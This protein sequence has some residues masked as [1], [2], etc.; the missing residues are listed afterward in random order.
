MMTGNP[1]VTVLMPVFNGA[2]HLA[3]TLESLQRQTFS[4]FE[5]LVV[6][7]GSTDDSM[8][9][10]RNVGDPRIRVISNDRNLGLVASLNRGSAEARGVFVA[11]QDADDPARH[12]RIARQVQF[13]QGNPSIPLLGS[14]ALLIDDS[15][16]WV[17]RW[18]SGG[19]ADLV[20][21]DCGFRT[22]FSHS[23]AMF[24]RD[25][26]VNRFGGY[27]DCR[28]CED[29]ELWGRVASE[30]PVVTLRQNLISYRQHGG[31][32]MAGE[33]AS[34]GGERRTA[35]YDV[36]VAN[37]RNL[38]PGTPDEQV[39]TIAT[40]WSQPMPD[41]DWVSYFAAVDGLKLGFLRGQRFL[42]GLG[43]VQADQNYMLLNRIVR[44]NRYS[45]LAALRRSDQRAFLRLPWLR[46]GLM[47]LR[48]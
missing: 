40:A 2:R 11:R 42:R 32:V 39:A 4:D 33:H 19:S 12:D 45:F 5:I 8:Q 17:G 22:P 16:R 34:N 44:K 13:M 1:T 3:E 24:R 48:R 10:V 23:S 36:L 25:I 41:V 20:R 9:I 35:L 14:D 27:R 38:A 31:S 43:R 29:L 30:L 46:V 26:I 47:L 6:D 28:A 15:G 7:D 18:R 21:W 37:L